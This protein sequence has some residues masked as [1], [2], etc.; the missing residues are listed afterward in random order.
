VCVFKSV[1]HVTI[2]L[3]HATTLHLDTRLAET[4]GA[5]KNEA[6]LLSIHRTHTHTRA[7]LSLHTDA[8]RIS[9]LKALYVV[10]LVRN[11]CVCV[12]G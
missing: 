4:V 1:N 8:T 6:F 7:S 2:L 9:V 11:V 10:H 3:I 12:I 5:C